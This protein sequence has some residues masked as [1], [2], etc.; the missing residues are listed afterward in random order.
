M[1]TK[2]TKKIY[3]RLAL[4]LSLIPM[5]TWVIV[6]LSKGSIPTLN[7]EILGDWFEGLPSW[8]LSKWWDVPG[9][10]VTTFLVHNCPEKI[11]SIWEKD[12]IWEKGQVPKALGY[13]VLLLCLFGLIVMLISLLLTNGLIMLCIFIATA[14]ITTTILWLAQHIH[15]P[16]IPMK[17][18]VSWIM[19][20]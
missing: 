3:W 8:V 4:V 6:Y 19:Q 12:S 1:E 13:L 14:I 5:V 16:S 10:F 15:I 20:K 7:P 17:K 18:I 11:N 9:I 2:K